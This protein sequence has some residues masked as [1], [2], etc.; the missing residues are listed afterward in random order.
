MFSLEYLQLMGPHF[1][2]NMLELW[3]QSLNGIPIET[4]KVDQAFLNI[5]SIVEKNVWVYQ[6]SDECDAVSL[7]AIFLCYLT[8]YICIETYLLH[9]Q[10]PFKKLRKIPAKGYVLQKINTDTNL[11]WSIYDANIGPYAFGNRSDRF[12]IF[13]TK[14]MY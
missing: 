14:F 6:L 9:F 7:F 8:I 4:L 1:S 5:S 10:C 2:H 12:S 3:Q 13:Y 11:R